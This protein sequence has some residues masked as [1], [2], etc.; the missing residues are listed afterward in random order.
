MLVLG[1]FNGHIAYD[2][3]SGVYGTNPQGSLLAEFID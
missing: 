2:S 1:D 3:S